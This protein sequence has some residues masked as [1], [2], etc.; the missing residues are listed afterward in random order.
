MT[1][2]DGRQEFDL[3]TIELSTGI[4]TRL[5]DD[6]PAWQFD[7]TWSPDG[8]RLAFNEKPIPTQGQF[9]L[10][11]LASN[12]RGAAESVV[13]REPSRGVTGPD[14]S[15]TN[16][17]VYNLG[18]DLWTIDMSG[19]RKP[20]LFLDTKYKE[21]NAKLSPD[22]R[23]IVHQS[24]ANGA[25]EVYVWPFPAGEPALRVSRDGGMYPVWRR[26]G[27][28]LFYLAPDGTMMAAGFDPKTGS[29]AAAPQKLFATPLRFGNN[30]PY[31]VSA[32]GQRFLIP[33]PVD[34]PPRLILDWRALLS[35]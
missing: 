33:L 20:R 7:P 6:Y 30:N 5:T 2:Q 25:L 22:G 19:D 23:W 16:T 10:S 27:R 13:P 15:L 17:I 29:V 21:M 11:M 26:D 32:D 4:A 12:G 24:D 18:E 3:W 34:V 8:Q 28:E 14:W 1:E 9:G 35:R 31:A